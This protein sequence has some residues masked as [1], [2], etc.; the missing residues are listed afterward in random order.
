MAKDNWLPEKT[1]PS[2]VG[3]RRRHSLFLLTVRP[4]WDCGHIHLRCGLSR[5]TSPSA[6][7]LCLLS[8]LDL[9]GG[10]WLIAGSRGIPTY[11]PGFKV[12]ASIVDG[13]FAGILISFWLD[14][15]NGHD[16]YRLHRA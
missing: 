2:W 10:S 4:S 13:R 12:P 3:S 14:Y 1:G 16:G 5:K 15:R 7:Q 8:L 11:K 6:F 9:R